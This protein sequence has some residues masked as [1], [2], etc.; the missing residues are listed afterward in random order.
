MNRIITEIEEVEKEDEENDEDEYTSSLW[1]Q[2]SDEYN[3]LKVNRSA[4]ED[5][6]AQIR[7]MCG[8]MMESRASLPNSAKIV[9]DA[10]DALE[11]IETAENLLEK[12]VVDW[13]TTNRRW[14]RGKKKKKPAQV[15]EENNGRCKWKVVGDD[16]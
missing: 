16:S 4:H 5:L 10:R 12:N 1:K 9:K 6:V 8:Y 14:I 7:V 15:C 3:K 11:K 2:I 13:T